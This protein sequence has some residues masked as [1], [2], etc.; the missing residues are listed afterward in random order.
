M[1]FRAVAILAVVTACSGQTPRLLHPTDPSSDF[2]EV[3][4]GIYRGGRLDQ[5]GVLRLH[6]L[7]FKTILNLE[8]DANQIALESVWAKAASVIRAWTAPGS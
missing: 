3:S 4:P 7:G 1:S 8:N 6:E 5:A 2:H